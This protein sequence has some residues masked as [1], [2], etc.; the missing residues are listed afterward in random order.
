MPFEVM[1]TSLIGL[2][3]VVALGGLAA[4]ACAAALVRRARRRI[5][6]PVL[7]IAPVLTVAS[8]AAAVNSY[9][10]YLPDVGSVL[11]RRAL[12]QASSAQVVHRLALADQQRPAAPTRLHGMVELARIPPTLS[13]FR[14]RLAQVYL[15]PAYFTSPRPHLPVIEL[16]HGTPGSPEDWTRAG[17]ADVSADRWATAHGGL[18]PI[19]VM[20]DP[21]GRWDADT[22]CVDG[23]QGR[24]ETYLAEDVPRW[25]IS[26]LAADPG[27]TSWAIAGS[28][29]GGF[30]ALDLA[31]RHR[32]RY[33]T[34]VDLAGL[35][36]A[37][38]AG[39]A[40]RLLPDPADLAA[41]DPRLVLRAE[42]TG[43][44]L[45]AWF[46]VGTA[47]GSVTRAV[48]S[49]AAAARA[50]GVEV[51]LELI[52]NAHH[53]WRVF[54]HGFTD[55]LPWTAARLRLSAT[56]DPLPP[57]HPLRQ[58]AGRPKHHHRHHAH[59]VHPT[60]RRSAEGKAQAQTQT[61]TAASR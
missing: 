42:R 32:D 18:G 1:K 37:T 23:T 2:P 48:R 11:G 61:S 34:V 12:D 53:T 56:V 22:E 8:V 52:P 13:G 41:H 38:F 47:D 9:F 5:R 15:P 14:A 28:S 49:V 33:A 55:A 27:R 4:L 57:V 21:N 51:H 30:C 7:A 44:P 3:F 50:T 10:A 6:W 25:A 19:I 59:E 40:A 60:R 31:V 20:P 43:P 54:R 17:H 35:D 45:A 46:A 39:G 29:E 36:R 16:L 26:A 58:V 24:A